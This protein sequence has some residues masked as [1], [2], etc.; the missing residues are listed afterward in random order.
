M[1]IVNI[2]SKRVNIFE[3]RLDGNNER[4]MIVLI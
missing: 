2:L 4:L 1:M 3:V